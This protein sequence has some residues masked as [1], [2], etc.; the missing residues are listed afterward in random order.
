MLRSCVLSDEER[1]STTLKRD[2]V[3]QL[4][5]THAKALVVFAS[6]MLGN[7][8]KAQDIVHQV[9]LRLIIVQ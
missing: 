5:R 7:Q 1:M 3:E 6:A 4:Y 9:F 8:T 2:E